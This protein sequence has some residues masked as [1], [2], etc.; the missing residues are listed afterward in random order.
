MSRK[1]VGLKSNEAKRK[2]III[3]KLKENPD[4]G[5]ICKLQNDRELRVE[6]VSSF[7]YL[8]VLITKYGNTKRQLD[9]RVVKG[10]RS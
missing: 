8:G 10:K 6:Y 7:V 1:K 3:R 4:K 5:I 9:A 2:C